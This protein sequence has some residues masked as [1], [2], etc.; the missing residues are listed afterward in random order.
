MTRKPQVTWIAATLVVAFLTTGNALGQSPA[1]AK[2]AIIYK[3]VRGSDDSLAKP[4]EFTSVEVFPQVVNY[5]PVGSQAK[6]RVMQTNVVA[7]VEFPN[8]S[9]GSYTTD[10]QFDDLRKQGAEIKA[11]SERYPGTKPSFDPIIQA[12]ADA[13][14]RR[15]TGQVLVSG[16]WTAK[17]QPGQPI[18]SA[19]LAKGAIPEL[20]V[21]D[22]LGRTRTYKNVR[23]T[24]IGS[25]SVQ[26]SH[27]S[28]A[29]SIPVEKLPKDILESPEVVAK[30]AEARQREEAR[31]A[32]VKDKEGEGNAA[33]ANA[34]VE[35]EKQFEALK[36]AIMEIAEEARRDFRYEKAIEMV[37]DENPLA[38]AYVL[39]AYSGVY[40]HTG[41]GFPVDET[42]RERHRQLGLS[43]GAVEWFRIELPEVPW[44]EYKIQK[45]DPLESQ[46][47]APRELDVKLEAPKMADTG[48]RLLQIGRLTLGVD[49]AGQR[50]VAF[51]WNGKNVLLDKR[52][53]N[54]FTR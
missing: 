36:P 23:V 40:T 39:G 26:I 47:Q 51:S 10:A 4:V 49:K 6:Q 19:P 7:V 5:T 34:R 43:K 30:L 35:A 1:A 12:I 32:A 53:A 31:L 24:S 3:A 48:E 44:E 41:Q 11:L 27:S 50:I 8:L 25:T 38:T 15:Q 9:G 54:P 33:M 14:N 42:E 17:A 45:G 22:E 2:G 52:D 13:L 20:A 46:W 28:G 29:A 18:P 21:T 37:L 16:K